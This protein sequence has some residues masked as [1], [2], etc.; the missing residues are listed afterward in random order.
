MLKKE[1][2]KLAKQLQVTKN[3]IVDTEANRDILKGKME[4]F[5]KLTYIIA[6]NIPIK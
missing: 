5:S 3:G 2:L 6:D 1:V 4:V